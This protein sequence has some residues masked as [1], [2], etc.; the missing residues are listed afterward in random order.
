[1]ADTPGLELPEVEAHLSRGL[2]ITSDADGTP[3]PAWTPLLRALD[4][5]L[6]VEMRDTEDGSVEHILA[7]YILATRSR[8]QKVSNEAP[9]VQL[10]NQSPNNVLQFMYT[11]A[12][13]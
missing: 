5:P 13:F 4:C 2:V 10:G 11:D 8:Q 6:L 12:H 3:A 9:L 1:M 7:F